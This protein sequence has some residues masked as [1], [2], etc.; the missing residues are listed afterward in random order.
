MLAPRS[1]ARLV[2]DVLASILG[3]LDYP[4][5]HTVPEGWHV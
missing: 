4:S 2:A 3:A 5:Y 1:R